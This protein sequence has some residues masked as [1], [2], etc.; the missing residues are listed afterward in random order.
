MKRS[1]ARHT[2]VRGN[3]AS[4]RAAAHVNYIAHRSHHKDEREQGGR[5][6]FDS[7]REG[8]SAKAVR[9]EVR[10]YAQEHGAVVH[11][12]MLSPGLNSVDMQEYTRELMDKLS[13]EKRQELEWKAVIH[14]NTDHI[15]AHVVLLGKDKDGH[16]VHLDRD[17]YNN[18]R[19]TG[20]QYLD[21][22]H[23]LE[24]YLDREVDDLLRSK[25][26]DRHGDARFR[27]LVFGAKEKERER[28]DKK[29]D[30]FL[31]RREFDKIDKDYRKY[32]SDVDRGPKTEFG[33]GYKQIVREQQGR[34]LDSH[35]HYTNSMAQLRINEIAGKDP[36]LA[37]ELQKELDHF[38]EAERDM[39]A[40]QRSSRERKDINRI[41]G[42]GQGEDR[43]AERFTEARQAFDMTRQQQEESGR[44]R[45][46]DQDRGEDMFARGG[47]QNRG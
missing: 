33:K 41:L 11:K 37:Q 24:R 34:M 27:S 39:M 1:I 18:L 12:L 23:K 42:I 19:R 6:F 44:E 31:D 7:E 28:E 9:E 8:I 15:H 30:P 35:G 45:D 2:Y 36:E 14:R 46:D 16:R 4:G 21:R 13:E 40:V 47:G 32:F 38:K 26:Y 10:E 17:D 3:R 29:R 43:S 5:K 20:D 25:V 22:E